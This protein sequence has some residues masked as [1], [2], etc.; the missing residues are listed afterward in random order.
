[1]YYYN[2]FICNMVARP[3]VARWSFCWRKWVFQLPQWENNRPLTRRKEDTPFFLFPRTIGIL[4]T[5]KE[6]RSKGDSQWRNKLTLATGMVSGRT[7]I[8]GSLC[9]GIDNGSLRAGCK[10]PIFCLIIFICYSQTINKVL[11][12][13]KVRY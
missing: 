4:V 6:G 2:C 12:S 9:R 10:I 8:K 7:A 1:M 11:W 13:I 3:I 5:C